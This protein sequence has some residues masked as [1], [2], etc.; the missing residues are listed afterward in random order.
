[1]SLAVFRKQRDA[2]SIGL[3]LAVLLV[4]NALFAGLTAG[5]AAP[6]ATVFCGHG[7]SGEPGA[8]ADQARHDHDCCVPAFA[9][10]QLATPPAIAGIPA[11]TRA[12]AFA[13]PA[14]L[15]VDNTP[16]LAREPRGPPLV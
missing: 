2:R 5:V 1:M 8:P 15:L 12:P 7:G 16:W 4:V 13:A 14:R 10:A 3:A 9:A 6:S 11:A